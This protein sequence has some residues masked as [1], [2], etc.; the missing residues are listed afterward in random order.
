[1]NQPYK[2]L[3]IGIVGLGHV[4]LTLAVHLTNGQS[5]IYGYENNEFNLECITRG[6]F[7]IHE[8]GLSDA[9]EY[10][11]Q[12]QKLIL[13]DYS[14]NDLD[15]L[16][17]SIGT[18]NPSTVI[19]PTNLFLDTIRTSVKLLKFGGILFLRS[20]VA[21]G[22]S[23]LV[24]E[25]LSEF[26][27]S[28]IYVCF[29]PERTAEGVALLEL[30]TLPQ[31]VGSNSEESQTQGLGCLNQLGF[32]TVAVSSCEVAELAKLI[33]N[34][35]R[36]TTFA[37]ANE[38][39]MLG[40]NLNINAQEAIGAANKDYPRSV[41]PLPGPVSGPCLSKDTY[42][43]HQEIPKNAYSVTMS[44]RKVNESFERHVLEVVTNQLQ[45]NTT[46]T[47]VVVAGLAFKGKPITFDTRDS[48]GMSI[49][50]HLMNNHKSVKTYVWEDQV[51]LRL[52]PHEF[53]FV[54]SIQDLISADLI[55][56]ANN[57][58][59]LT[60]EWLITAL[61]KNPDIIVIDVWGVLPDELRG[62]IRYKLLGDGSDF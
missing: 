54:S 43:L 22:T 42:I 59:F 30:K 21:L 62:Q 3:R 56:L 7:S 31:I 10:A 26:G 49:T 48:I 9:I 51:P 37:F 23:R 45:R 5:K 17:I 29:A 50:S 58:S 57:A 28:D 38:I 18:P 39:A 55:V 19:E 35:W 34:T 36:D 11:L 15:A 44:A 4:G 20:T 60:S 12:E 46:L 6:S 47:N 27:R 25:N 61:A 53:H 33:C 1:M 24:G 40:D 52:L 16:F 13:N 14:L 32:Q 8:P 41:V 2:P